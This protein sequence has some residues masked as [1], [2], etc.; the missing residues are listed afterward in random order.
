MEVL[1]VVGLNS[2]EKEKFQNLRW[3]GSMW[4]TASEVTAQEPLLPIIPE[5][6]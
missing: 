6:V 2:V 3:E 1:K 5:F 4:E